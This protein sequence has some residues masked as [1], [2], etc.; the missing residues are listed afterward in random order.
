MSDVLTFESIQK[1]V[2]EATKREHQFLESIGLQEDPKI[3]IGARWRN[4]RRRT[5]TVGAL[6]S[7]ARR[8]RRD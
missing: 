2:A 3:G 7:T 1:A 8:V 5:I 4:R 6:T